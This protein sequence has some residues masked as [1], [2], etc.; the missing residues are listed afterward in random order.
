MSTRLVPP[1]NPR[2]PDPS[3]GVDAPYISALLNVLRLFFNQLQ[4]VVELVT[5]DNGLRFLQTPFA[6]FSSSVTQTALVNTATLVQFADVV[7]SNGVSVVSNTDITAAFTGFY[8]LN[9]SLR[10]A[11]SSTAR[12]I[13]VWLRVGGVDVAGSAREIPVGASAANGAFAQLSWLVPLT[14]GESV[15]VVWSTP[16]VSVSLQALPTRSTPTRPA[17]PSA[18]ATIRLA[19][20][21]LNE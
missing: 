1:Q 19:S 16:A 14:G 8:T 2:L 4:R 21:P 9:V 10:L 6:V 20:A 17:A 3:R 11:N 5:G 15:R 13:S 12:V 18:T 7:R